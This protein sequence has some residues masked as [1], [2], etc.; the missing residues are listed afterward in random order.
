MRVTLPPASRRP[1][2]LAVYLVGFS[3]LS[4]HTAPAGAAGSL[5]WDYAASGAAGFVVYCGANPGNYTLRT[6][7]GNTLTATLPSL[8]AGGTY[9]CAVTAYDSSRQE[10]PYSNETTVAVPAVAANPTFSAAP[11]TGLAPLAV[12]FTDTTGQL[13]NWAWDFGDGTTSTAQNPA[14]TYASGGLYTV[15]LTG[16]LS[17]GT[18]GQITK[19]NA[20]TVSQTLWSANDRPA[21]AAIPDSQ[22]VNVGM[23]FYTS[24]SGTITG[25]RFY[26]GMANTGRHIA[27]LW[28]TSG[29]KLAEAAFVNE[30]ASGWQQV[31]FPSPVKITAGT[32]YVASYFTPSGGYAATRDY[33]T[34]SGATRGLLTAPVSSNIALNGV[35]TYA[36][37][38]A[39]PRQSWR[40]T[41]Y[42]VDVIFTPA[43]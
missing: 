28:S 9:Y 16:R 40:D 22:P 21:Q 4:M 2:A 41:N 26:K 39:F 5:Q 20:I 10:S 32:R 36:S 34:Y 31:I 17:D 35:F 1:S 11:T 30:T 43:P 24:K 25:L 7:V 37:T 19:T 27:N 15:T 6:D 12:K 18:I 8:A 3:L 14:H 13:S 38:T 29:Q 42:W 23:R 33:F